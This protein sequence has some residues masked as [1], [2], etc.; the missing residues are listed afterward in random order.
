M[1]REVRPPGGFGE[2]LDQQRGPK[3][4]PKIL[5]LTQ[6]SKIAPL[7]MG[8][9]FLTLSHHSRPAQIESQELHKSFLFT[10]LILCMWI[11]ECLGA[12][13]VYSVP[14]IFMCR[15]TGAKKNMH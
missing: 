5:Y 7:Y 3:R 6:A 10:H 1:P 14:P 12:K 2:H 11:V 4:G 13:G 9:L 8:F 15:S